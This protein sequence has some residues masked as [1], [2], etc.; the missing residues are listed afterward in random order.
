[1]LFLIKFE[2]F[3]YIY[4]VPM[5][6]GVQ[7]DTTA[8]FGTVERDAI[9]TVVFPIRYIINL[10][11]FI[12]NDLEFIFVNLVR[13]NI[14]ERIFKFNDST[15]QRSFDFVNSGGV[16]A[17]NASGMLPDE[18]TL[19]NNDFLVYED[20]VT[21]REAPPSTFVLPITFDFDLSFLA[22]GRSRETNEPIQLS[23]SALGI[24]TITEPLGKLHII[25]S[26]I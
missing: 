26:A 9:G 15:N 19:I 17:V 24:V 3:T 7:G 21:Y 23:Q 22:T 10:T 2:C 12:G 1:M 6:F 5:N 11:K 4:T 20:N 16:F 13:S 25:F 18:L 14:V 8:Y